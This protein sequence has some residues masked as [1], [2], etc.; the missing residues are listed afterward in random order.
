[1]RY[2]SA[3][4][5][6]IVVIISLLLIGVG[7]SVWSKD[8]IAPVPLFAVVAYFAWAWFGTNYII[9][10]NKLMYRSALLRGSVKIDTIFE[11]V[12]NKHQYSGIKAVLSTKGLLIKYNKWDDVYVSPEDAEGFIAKLKAINPNIDVVDGKPVL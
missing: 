7:V 3:K 4:G 10:D 8:Y 5:A 9:E 2:N 11:N 12:K 6:I 1:M